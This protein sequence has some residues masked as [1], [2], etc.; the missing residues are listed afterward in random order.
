VAAAVKVRR[1]V[2]DLGRENKKG[3][4]INNTKTV[5]RGKKKLT[6]GSHKDLQKSPKS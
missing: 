4:Q 1:V 3:K 5:E 2:V 6:G